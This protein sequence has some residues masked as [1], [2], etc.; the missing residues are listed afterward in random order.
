MNEVISDEEEFDA[1][2]A[3]ST[4]RTIVTRKSK[5][6]EEEIRLGEEAFRNALI[7]LEA[8]GKTA[9][10]GET[11]RAEKGREVWSENG[12][13]HLTEEQPIEAAS[14][15]LATH[16]QV[17]EEGGSGQES[18]QSEAGESAQEEILLQGGESS[19]RS[20]L[21][22]SLTS[23]A[24]IDDAPGHTPQTE[25]DLQPGEPAVVAPVLQGETASEASG[26]DLDLPADI[27]GRLNSDSLSERSLGLSELARLGGESAFRIIARAFDEEHEDVR[28][29]A[30]LALFELQS[31]RVASFARTL[32]EGSPERRRRIGA[33]LTKSG[34][35]DI[36][37][38]KLA[39]KLAS[40]VTR[41][42]LSCS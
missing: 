40:R 19:H 20:P 22:G 11:E 38:G 28:N 18:P 23:E 35:A 31:D 42:S 13:P 7:E 17:D 5:L 36:E 2:R 32:R 10:E 39:D 25:G 26:E 15:R 33:A 9:A 41:H 37:I 12:G 4:T 16:V 30:A 29:A 27:I 3:A 8:L 24:E 21:A 14:W 1:V 6:S 34:L